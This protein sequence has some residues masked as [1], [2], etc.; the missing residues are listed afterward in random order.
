MRRPPDAD[1]ATDVPNEGRSK[2]QA[3][4]A[5]RDR[6]DVRAQLARIRAHDVRA[7]RLA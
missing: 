5:V 2:R 3:N 1:R 6:G 4:H 7:P